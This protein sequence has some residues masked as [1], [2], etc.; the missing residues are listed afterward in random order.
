MRNDNTFG[1]HFILRMNKVKDGKGPIYARIVI[2]GSRCEISLKKRVE[3]RDWNGSKGLAKP[4]SN[5][6][7]FL[8]NYLEEVR[9]QLADCYR[10]IHLEKKLLNAEQVKN[11][12]L[13]FKKEEYT[14]NTLMD[15]HNIQLKEVLAPGTLKNYFTTVRYVKSFLRSL[16]KTTDIYL[17]ELNYRFISEFEMFLRKHIPKDHQKKITE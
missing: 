8:N 10:Q 16:H 13:G 15:Y 4:K 17:A 5:D 14:L 2:N 9:G 7:K 11:I 12:W 3:I 1:I 6:L